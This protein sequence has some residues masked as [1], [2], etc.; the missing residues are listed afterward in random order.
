MQL[1]F[2]EVFII[3]AVSMLQFSLLDHLVLLLFNVQTTH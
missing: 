1:A 3:V 2:P